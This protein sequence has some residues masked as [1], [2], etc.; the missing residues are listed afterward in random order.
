MKSRQPL[1]SIITA[2]FATVFVTAPLVSVSAQ[3][4][5]TGQKQSS[6]SQTDT[7]REKKPA[8][9][10]VRDPK[11]AG[12]QSDRTSV[13]RTTAPR[14]K[15]EQE[16]KAMKFADEHHPELAGLLRQLKKKSA[17]QYMRGIR[18][19]WTT[20]QRLERVRERQPE[21]FESQVKQWKC[22]S[23][24]RLL[25]ARYVLTND[26]DLAPKIQ[27][28]LKSHQESKLKATQVERDRI[29][30]RLRE[31]DTDLANQKKNFQKNL[32]VEWTRI[33]KQAEASA[34]NRK[35]TDKNVTA[36]D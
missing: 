9:P 33:R 8:K 7:V 21:R 18:E 10:T 12:Q 35:R 11:R 24:I 29:A 2:V 14:L 25:T 30:A 4:K 20:S 16:A 5:D 13:K 1:Q 26:E 27:S 6:S 15:T 17:P 31:L 32:D 36:K 3:E 28:L 22:Y 19:V 23:E 34:R